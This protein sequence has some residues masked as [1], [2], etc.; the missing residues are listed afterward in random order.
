MGHTVT[1]ID[2]SETMLKEAEANTARFGVPERVTRFCMDAQAPDLPEGSFDAVVSRNLTWMFSDLKAVYRRWLSLLRSGGRILV[3]DCNWYLYCFIPSLYRQD[4][5]DLRSA[6]AMGYPYGEL[7]RVYTPEHPP[8]PTDFP[9][10]DKV[11]P[12]WDRRLLETLPVSD[13]TV[14]AELPQ[15]MRY[16]TYAIRYA[17]T[18]YFVVCAEK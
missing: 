14:K 3:F 13:I 9:L 1:A 5:K 10:A 15:N 17:H 4:E 2:F 7:S 16:G 11:R 18:P 8:D 6:V 12:E